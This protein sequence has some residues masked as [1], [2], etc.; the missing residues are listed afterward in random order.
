MD[1]QM[2]QFQGDG[3]EP[4]LPVAAAEFWVAKP[5]QSFTSLHLRPPT[6][7][8]PPASRSSSKHSCGLETRHVKNADNSNKFFF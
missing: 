1:Q 6:P 4:G 7:P 3:S 2:K 8:P 5:L